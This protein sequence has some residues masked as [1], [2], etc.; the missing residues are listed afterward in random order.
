MASVPQ[1]LTIALQELELCRHRL[2]PDALGISSNRPVVGCMEYKVTGGAR[3]VPDSASSLIERVPVSV[4]ELRAVCTLFLAIILDLALR[5]KHVFSRGIW[6]A[7]V[8]FLCV[9]LQ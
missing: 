1:T 4:Y 6:S 5:G 7:L 8:F 3:S 2:H 9:I